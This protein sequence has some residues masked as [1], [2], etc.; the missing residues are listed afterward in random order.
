MHVYVVDQTSGAGLAAVCRGL[1]VLFCCF[2]GIREFGRWV[3]GENTLLS[4][5]GVVFT[6]TEGEMVRWMSGEA[7]QDGGF[8]G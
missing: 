3:E 7:T 6:H 5:T 2:W 1:M 8:G 4:G